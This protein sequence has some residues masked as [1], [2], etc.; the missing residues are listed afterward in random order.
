MHRTSR[1]CNFN[2]RSYKESTLQYKE[3]ISFL[4]SQ[5]LT[6]ST[7]QQ[8]KG[9]NR[10]SSVSKARY[11]CCRLLKTHTLRFTYLTVFLDL[12][13][14]TRSRAMLNLQ[15]KTILLLTTLKTAMVCQ[16]AVYS[17]FQSSR[18]KTISLKQLRHTS[19]KCK[20]RI[21]QISS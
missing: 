3:F 11:F 19:A 4:H 18:K 21:P 15:K 7:N 5:L 6:R 2:L 1:T 14:R 10:E 16:S 20:T 9:L 13:S 17:T 12:I 8:R